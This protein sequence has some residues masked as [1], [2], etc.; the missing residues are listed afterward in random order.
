VQKKACRSGCAQVPTRID[1]MDAPRK[2]VGI[3]GEVY[4]FERSK[5]MSGVCMAVQYR[6]PKD[7]VSTTF[8]A[9]Q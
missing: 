8:F 6:D 7:G 5:D 9:L 4:F 3:Q 1:R 2:G